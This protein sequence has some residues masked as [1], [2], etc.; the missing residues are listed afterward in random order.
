MTQKKCKRI[1]TLISFV[2]VLAV[3][4]GAKAQDILYK[5]DSLFA[6][7]QYLSAQ[8]IYKSHVGQEDRFMPNAILKMAYIA[9]INGDYTQSLYYL[10][11]LSKVVP[12]EAI[13][14]KMEAVALKNRLSGYSFDDFGYF[15]LYV[16]K[17]GHWLYLFLVF[18]TGYILFEL[19][20]KYRKNEEINVLP[21]LIV[22]I[23]LIGLLVILNVGALYQEGI[24]AQSPTF[25]RKSPSSASTV[26]GTVGKGN[27][28]I[29]LGKRDHWKMVLLK[30]KIVYIRQ[31]DLLTI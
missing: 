9:E 27:K 29:V 14:Q 7:G 3:T 19:F 13:Y 25:L 23:L 4:S 1:A 5:A 24:V 2:C 18:F 6:I 21:K 28:V 12:S 10:S 11:V 31:S 22:S 8:E 26:V 15:I 30:G 20:V 17:Y 16:K